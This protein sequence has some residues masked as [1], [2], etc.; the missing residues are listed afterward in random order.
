MSLRSWWRT[1]EI[2]YAGEIPNAN[3]PGSVGPPGYHPGDPNGFEFDRT[4]TF[5]RSLAPF[6]PSPWSG[7]PADWSTPNFGAGPGFGQLVDTAWAGLDLNSSVI[8]AMPVYR[9]VGGEIDDPKSWMSNPDPSIYTSWYEFAKQLFWD[10]MLGEVF[11]LPI[12]RNTDGYPRTMRVIPGAFVKVEMVKGLRSYH[13]GQMDVTADILHIRYQSTTTTAHGV[14][15]LEAAGARMV[16]AGVMS[17]HIED[18]ISTGGTP[19]YVLEIERAL[20]RQQADDV[21]EQWLLSRAGSMGAP[22]LLTGGTK[23][24]SVQQMSPKDLALLELAQWNESR[25]AIALGV[26]PFLLG[27]PSGGDSMTYS[28]VTSLFDFHDRSSIRPKVT[29]VMSA[30]SN[31]ALPRGQC[32]ELNRDEYTRPALAERA[33]AYATLHGIVDADGL[34]ALSAAEVRAMERFHGEPS[35][36]ALT[37]GDVGA[38]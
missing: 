24:T 30:L 16:T 4:E 19:R 13:I 14:G 27:L 9:T 6:I 20:N 15:P 34:S 25:I 7:W 12:E 21:M 26:P 37:G 33:T 28:N 17:R 3:P 18:V 10:F 38:Y 23:L 31:W 5:S 36:V 35:A 11:V 29:A 2:N 1:G 32:V 8:A 22:A